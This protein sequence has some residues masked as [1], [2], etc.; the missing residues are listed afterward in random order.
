MTAWLD[1]RRRKERYI[2]APV[3]SL[4]HLSEFGIEKGYLILGLPKNLYLRKGREAKYCD[5]L[6]KQKPE[7][8]TKLY[9]GP[10]FRIQMSFLGTK[11]HALVG[12]LWLLP[13]FSS[14]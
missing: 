7:M 6:A 12:I 5:S 13:R 2:C 1:R 8:W 10:L 4:A 14:I 11:K 3:F 9:F